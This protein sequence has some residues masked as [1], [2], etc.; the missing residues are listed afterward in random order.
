MYTE[1]SDGKGGKIKVKKENPKKVAARIAKEIAAIK[2]KKPKDPNAVF[3]DSDATTDSD[4]VDLE[5]MTEEEK[6]AYFEGKAARA[7]AREARRREKY[8]DKYDE[9][10]AKHEEYETYV[11]WMF[12]Y[13]TNTRLYRI[14]IQIF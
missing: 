13:I 5:N 1:V 9:M 2:K 4:D 10:M 11:W 6:K 7:A 14:I 8:G 3:S 12:I